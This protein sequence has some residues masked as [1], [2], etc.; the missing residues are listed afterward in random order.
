MTA[1]LLLTKPSEDRIQRFI[2]DQ[3]QKSFSYKDVGATRGKLPGGYV[4]DSNM[5]VLS[6]GA[7]GFER[8]KNALASWAM[9]DIPWIALHSKTTPIEEG[10]TVA[11]TAKLF[12]IYSMNACRIV[13]TIDE[14]DKTGARFGFA[15]GTLPDHMESGEER[16]QVKWDAKSDLVFYELLAFSR[17]AHFIAKFGRPIARRC[18]KR[19][20][21]QSMEAMTKA[22]ATI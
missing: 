7:Q 20:A 19:F 11:V 5:T 3:S 1:V 15:Y 12:G 2:E 14:R 4:L 21:E 17:P 22:T 8:A 16:F 18:Q 9:F 13:Y 6:S 10:R